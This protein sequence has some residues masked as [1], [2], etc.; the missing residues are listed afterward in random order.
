A[1]RADPAG[2]AGGGGAVRFR[3][4]AGGRRGLAAEAPGAAARSAAQRAFQ[5]AAGAAGLRGGS[6]ADRRSAGIDARAR[7]GRIDLEGARVAV[8]EGPLARVAQAEG[9]GDARA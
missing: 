5:R 3:S 8:R 6:G 7:D 1:V 9:A 2:A 4:A